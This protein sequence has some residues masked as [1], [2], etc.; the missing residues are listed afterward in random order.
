MKKNNI[1]QAIRMCCYLFLALMLFSCEKEESAQTTSFEIDSDNSSIQGS[2]VQNTPLSTLNT[3]NL[4]YLGGGFTAEISAKEVNGVYISEKQIE[5]GSDGSIKIPIEGKPIDLGSYTLKLEIDINGKSYYCSQIFDVA[6]DTDPNAPIIFTMETEYN[7]INGLTQAT[8]IPFTVDPFMSSIVLATPVDGLNVKTTIDKKSGQGIF[9]LTPGDNF[10]GGQ[11]DLVVSFGARKTVP[12]SIAVSPFAN[13][14][15]T[16]T[17][18]YEINSTDLLKKMQYLLDKNFKLIND[19]DLSGIIWQPLG[20]EA[21]KFSGSLDGNG[22][23][24]SNINIVGTDNVGFFAYTTSSAKIRNLTISGSVTGNNFVAGLVAINAGTVSNCNAANMNVIGNNNMSGIVAKNSGGNISSSNPTEILTLNNFPAMISEIIASVTKPLNYAPATATATIL[25][26]PPTG[27]KITAAI[28][29]SSIVLTPQAEFVRSSVGVK[30][31][32]GKV[33]SVEKIILLYAE[34]QFDGG[35][36]SAANPFL[37]SKASQFNKMRSYT[38]KYFLV[39]AD[40][41]L[42]DL[43]TATGSPWIPIPTFSGAID[44]GGFQVKGLKYKAELPYE[45]ISTKGGLITTNTGNIKNLSFPDIDITAKGAFGVIA[46]DHTGGTISNIVVKGTLTSKNTGDLLGGIVAEITG[47][48]ITNVYVNLNMT[49]SCGMTGGIV[50]R[51]KTATSTISN[52]TSEGTLTVTAGKNRIGGIVGR[53]ETAVIIKNCL[54]TMNITS[55]VAGANGVGGIFGANNNN[56]MRIDECMFTGK[57]SNVFSTGGIAGVAANIRN[58]VVEGSGAGMSSTMI[59]VDG[60]INTGSAGGIVGTGKIIIEKCITR[61]AAFTGVTTA[62]LPIAGIV[63]TFQDNGY[64]SNCVVSNVL[65][66]GTTVHGIAGTAANGTGVSS[67]NYA[68]GVLYYE[69]GTSS[70][71]VP[72]DNTSGL[73]GAT[74]AQADL[75]QAFYTSLGFDFANIWNWDGNKPVLKNVGYKGTVAV[76]GLTA[77]RR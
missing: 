34:E 33:S 4:H 61:N 3:F 72:V 27:D 44:G 46:G 9:T 53:G 56:N 50:G 35:D 68:A 41:N 13:G 21:S 10:I 55:T 58:C 37:I 76:A 48:Q 62:S 40:I 36:G 54:S 2:Y 38:D 32:L 63:S 25:T 16:A 26:A 64:A 49:S 60:S 43:V 5:F 65:L 22:K 52:C 7:N 77:K 24:I 57:I 51:A 30:V 47:G 18:P 70:S 20:T 42:A 28:S 59:S 45:E 39:T 67:S 31:S 71:Y 75:T 66:N 15:G 1:R 19:I 8:E 73:D 69:N 6:E 17:S 11:L 74:K 23:T 12:V 14:D 29:G